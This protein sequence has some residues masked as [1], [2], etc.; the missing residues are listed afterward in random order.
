[1][2]LNEVKIGNFFIVQFDGDEKFGIVTNINRSNHQVCIDNSVQEFWYDINQLKPMQI[3][4][5]ALLQL[6][7]SKQNNQDGTIKYSKGA[8]R[9]LIP[10]EGD[11]SKMEIWYRDEHRHIFKTLFVHELQNHFQSMTKV[12][13]NSM[14]Y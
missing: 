13:L 2:Q 5:K 4:E 11:F 6:K 9:V 12:E 10:K 1:M 14:E 8:F 7:F 3:N